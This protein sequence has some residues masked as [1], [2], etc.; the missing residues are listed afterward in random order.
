MEGRGSMPKSLLCAWHDKEAPCLIPLTTLGSGGVSDGV[1]E[2]AWRSGIPTGVV[3]RG[4]GPTHS[5]A[6]SFALSM[7]TS[8]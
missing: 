5:K 8:L 2:E 1:T 3:D 4:S 7:N 6:H